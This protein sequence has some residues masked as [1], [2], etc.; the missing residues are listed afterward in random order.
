LY[1][2]GS[3]EEEAR[4]TLDAQ[5][6]ALVLGCV[7][8]EST[9]PKVS[10]TTPNPDSLEKVDK[11]PASKLEK[12]E[13]SKTEGKNQAFKLNPNRVLLRIDHNVAGYAQ[14]EARTTLYFG[15]TPL[16]VV[17]SKYLTE[18][19]ARKALDYKVKQLLDRLTD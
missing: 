4:A 9:K 10:S 16:E 17:C 7:D 5:F 11:T 6:E 1:A 2:L 15:D 14:W 12:T 19:S 8:N 3:S 18:E 13:L